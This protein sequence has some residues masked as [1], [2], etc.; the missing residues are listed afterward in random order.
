MTRV[1]RLFAMILMTL[2]LVASACA[3]DAYE[4]L[5][6]KDSPSSKGEVHPLVALTKTLNSRL[7]PEL[8][9]KHPRVFFT[10]TEFE[11]LRVRAH[12]T[13]KD[14]WA[15]ALQNV[16]AL[17]GDPPP[18]PA[19]GRREQN[20]VA[21]AIAESSFLYQVSGDRK[22]LD[23][24]KKYMEAATTYDVWG[25]RFNKPNVDLAAGHLL[26]GMSVGYDLLYNDLSPAERERYRNDIA[27]HAR[28]MYDY[29]KLKPGRSFAYSQNH[30][31]IPIA[32]LGIA[33]YALYDEVPD[34][35]QW[36]ALARAI[37][38]RVLATYSPDGYY[39]EGFEYWVFSTPWIIHYLDAHK[40]A[41]GEDLYDH[42]GLKQ[43]YL[44][45]A[46]VLTPGG[47][48]MFDF[49]DVF[50]GPL[51][52]AKKGEEYERS[53]PGGHLH[54]NYNL[55]YHLAAR[56]QNPDAQG[57]AKFMADM[58]QVNFEDW[59]SLA[60]YDDKLPAT[61]MNQL[62]TWHYFPDHEVVFWRSDWT[63]NATAFAFKAGPPEGHHTEALLK[64]FPDWHLSAGH[65]HPDANSF[66]IFAKGQY[67]TGDSGYSG[68]PRTEQHNT[69]L[70]DG[71]GQGAEGGHHDPWAKFPYSQLN[72]T[73]ISE[74]QLANGF[75]YVKG[76]ASAAYEKTLELKKFNRHFLFVAPSQFTIWDDIESK[77]PRVFTSILHSDTTW[78]EVGKKN[79]AVKSGEAKLLLNIQ[80]SDIETKTE[81][82]LV[83][84]PGR[85]GAVDKGEQQ[86]RGERL[87]ISTKSAQR[88]AIFVYQIR[89]E[90]AGGAASGSK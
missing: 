8:R 22:Y 51:T 50:E 33:A 83:I 71:R 44:Y 45:L 12:S 1:T 23:A 4:A 35:P 30:V 52:R 49:G 86:Q 84:A 54:T 20:E 87:A 79:F 82:N 47:E 21:L 6:P 7:L 80:N 37:Y 29:Y 81:P 67:L 16:R 27:R 32:G 69:L 68:Q 11:Q 64:K 25:Y 39:Y 76:E 88:S 3:Q 34:A 38:D 59:W 57:V 78:D 70:V 42:P 13:H 74:M 17:K 65:S 72:D 75:A 10:A 28:Q 89:V 31:F 26:Y 19:E 18:P 5:G 58:G 62:S 90:D 61:P 77:E 63:A 66:I 14:L 48:T 36:A 9:G 73:R 15:R 53:H 24:A 55:L 40:H 43:A 85:P 60:W 2:A 56:F 41:T 46:H